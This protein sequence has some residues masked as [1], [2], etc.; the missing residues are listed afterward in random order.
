MCVIT[1]KSRLER[2]VLRS[3]LGCEGA[4][5]CW[6]AR[7]FAKRNKLFLCVWPQIEAVRGDRRQINRAKKKKNQ[8][9]KENVKAIIGRVTIPNKHGKRS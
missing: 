6:R 5:G 7:L 9:T 8:K 2:F 1:K 4:G 3:R